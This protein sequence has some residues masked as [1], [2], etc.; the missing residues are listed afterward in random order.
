LRFR[1]EDIDK[2][3]AASPEAMRDVRIAMLKASAGS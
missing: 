1:I 3:K 2:G